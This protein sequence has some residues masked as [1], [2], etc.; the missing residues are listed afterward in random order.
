[1]FNNKKI[2]V[3][4]IA[5]SG[6]STL[7]AL[8]KVGAYVIINDVKT[9]DKLLDI[10][11]QIEGLYNEKILGEHPTNYSNIDMMV[12]S[13]G[14]PTD[15]EFIKEAREQGVRIIGELELAY[16]LSN[17]KKFI[18][19]TGTNGKTTT[20]ALSGEMFLD[21][22]L[23]AHVVGNIGIP[24]VSVALENDKDD[25]MITEVSSFQLETI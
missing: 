1:M 7:K 22:G 11:P 3:V 16:R 9:E 21:F 13:P 6:I 20:T 18:G 25:F 5:R 4:G 17:S 15:L 24:A 10:L 14:V 12:L 8:N 2:I 19:I 23:K